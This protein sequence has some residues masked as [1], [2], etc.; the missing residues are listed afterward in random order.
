[1]NFF[2]GDRARPF[3]NILNTTNVCSLTDYSSDCANGCK[4]PAN[5]SISGYCVCPTTLN[6]VDS[7]DPYQ[8]TCQCNGHP[9]VYFN[10]SDCVNTT[11]N[12]P[13]TD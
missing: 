12:I 4:Y 6:L 13:F 2:L 3:E 9:F 10:D 11:G 8:Q 7:S 1:M 5:C